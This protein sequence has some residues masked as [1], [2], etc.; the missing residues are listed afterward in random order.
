LQALTF[1][2]LTLIST[3]DSV[4]F[5]LWLLPARP[6]Y[7]VVAQDTRLASVATGCKYG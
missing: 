5:W 6:S 7:G 2:E 3:G 4:T 1:I